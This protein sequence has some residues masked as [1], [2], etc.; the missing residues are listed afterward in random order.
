M[1]KTNKGWT[2]TVSL[3]LDIAGNDKEATTRKVG[4]AHLTGSD[5]VS[6]LASGLS[7]SGRI[8]LKLKEDHSA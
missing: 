3:V 6:E 5:F 4:D 2:Y 7:M 1:D 8:V